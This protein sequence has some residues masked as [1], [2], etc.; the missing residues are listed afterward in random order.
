MNPKL[1]EIVR[2]LYDFE[3]LGTR[4]KLVEM[5]STSTYKAPDAYD[6]L[7]AGIDMAYNAAKHESCDEPRRQ[8]LIRWIEEANKVLLSGPPSTPGKK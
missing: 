8:M 7:Y 4:E 3:R 5:L 2:P 1:A 6:D